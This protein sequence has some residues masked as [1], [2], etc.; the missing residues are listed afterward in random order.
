MCFTI[1]SSV[2]VPNYNQIEGPQ[3]EIFQRAV[4]NLAKKLSLLHFTKLDCA[5][6][7]AS[8]FHWSRSSVLF[9]GL[10]IPLFYDL[11]L[12]TFESFSILYQ[13]SLII[14][15]CFQSSIC[16]L[17]TSTIRR[18]FCSARTMTLIVYRTNDFNCT[19]QIAAR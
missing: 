16:R 11:I 19:S 9:A 14:S 2:Q 4:L 12:Y 10:T 17:S 7:Y 1:S 13:S 5:L 6:L 8:N 15:R 3:N 18:S